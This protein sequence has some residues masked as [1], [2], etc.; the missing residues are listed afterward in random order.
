MSYTKRIGYQLNHA[1]ADQAAAGIDFVLTSTIRGHVWTATVYHG[2]RRDYARDGKPAILP[3]YATGLRDVVNR[4][5]RPGWTAP[6]RDNAAPDACI[7]TIE[8]M[9]TAD[10]CTMHDHERSEKL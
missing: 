9:H 5:R 6:A 2:E 1:T 4:L 10:D 7:L 3:V 8:N